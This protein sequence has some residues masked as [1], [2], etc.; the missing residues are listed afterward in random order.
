[1]S[2]CLKWI[3]G[4]LFM[5]PI[6]GVGLSSRFVAFLFTDRWPPTTP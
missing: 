1:M 5:I 6:T 2:A 3:F 4:S